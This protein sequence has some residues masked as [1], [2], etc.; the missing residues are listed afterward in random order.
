MNANYNNQ[1]DEAVIEK[2][3]KKMINEY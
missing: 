1:I 2:L 3:N